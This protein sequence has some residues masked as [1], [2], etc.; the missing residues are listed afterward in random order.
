MSQ[1]DEPF[2]IPLG[3]VV[4]EQQKAHTLFFSGEICGLVA[5]SLSEAVAPPM[6]MSTKVKHRVSNGL[7]QIGAEETQRKRKKIVT[8]IKWN[9]QILFE[10]PRKAKRDPDKA[11]DECCSKLGCSGRYRC[12]ADDPTGA[13]AIRFLREQYLALT[14]DQQCEFIGQRVRLAT[15]SCRK[16]TYMEPLSV[17]QRYQL[18]GSIDIVYGAYFSNL[19]RCCRDWFNFVL[20]ISRDKVTQPGV[21]DARYN[22]SAATVRR[23]YARRARPALRWCLVVNWLLM[24]SVYYLHDPAH[25]FIYLPFAQRQAVYDL[26][27]ADHKTEFPSGVCHYSW[28][29]HIW[30][31]DSRVTHIRL[32]KHLRFALCP[33]CAGF[34]NTRFHALGEDVR[35][36]IKAKE[37]AHAVF[38]RREREA[39]YSRRRLAY[40]QPDNY[41]SM[42]AD[43]ADQSAYGLPHFWI[44]DKSVTELYRLRNHLMGVIVHGQGLYGF[45]FLDNFKHGANITI[46]A[47]H[48]VLVKEF[49]R[50]GRIPMPRTFFLQLDNTTKQCKSQYI[51]AYLGLLVGWDVFEEVILSFLP[52]GHTHEDIDQLFSRIATYLRRHDARAR[53]EFHEAFCHSCRSK[54]WG[55]GP[56]AVHS[57]SESIDYCANFSHLVVQEGFCV[58]DATNERK[59]KRDGLTKFHQIK[60]SKNAA[61]TVQMLVRKWCG[62]TEEESPWRSNMIADGKPLTDV[63]GAPVPHTVFK[64]GLTP[65]VS[66][67]ERMP[68]MQRK[69]YSKELRQTKDGDTINT[70]K[71]KM[72]RDIEKLITNRTSELTE[73]IKADLRT[74]LAL[75]MDEEDYVHEWDTSIYEA[76][77][78]RTCANPLDAQG[79]NE[80]MELNIPDSEEDVVLEREEPEFEADDDG[81]SPGHGDFEIDDVWLV[82][83]VPDDP[84]GDGWGL[85]R[86]KG[87]PILTAES[88]AHLCD[89]EGNPL[90]N[91]YWM[92][93]VMWLR[94]SERGE[95][96][97]DVSKDTYVEEMRKKASHR[98]GW[99]TVYCGALG[100]LIDVKVGSRANTLK[101]HEDSRDTVRAAAAA[102]EAKGHG[103]KKNVTRTSFGEPQKAKPRQAKKRT[104]PEDT[105]Q[106][107]TGRAK[108]SAPIMARE[109]VTAE[110]SPYPVLGTRSS[111]RR[112]PV[113]A[114]DIEGRRKLLYNN[115]MMR[116]TPQ[117]QSAR[118]ADMWEEAYTM[119]L[120]EM[121]SRLD[122]TGPGGADAE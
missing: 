30:K 4:T 82:P 11:I 31:N 8:L 18:E 24:L 64:D 91:Q 66:V 96:K 59:N 7:P 1:A 72:R 40:T 10:T 93:Q 54:T 45:S 122:S 48:R 34:I 73:E 33:D 86:I 57:F 25:E 61:G 53:Q 70:M 109:R 28:F 74:C 105:D 29:K 79:S 39:Y 116:A 108:G 16:E 67:L 103:K 43:G 106:E 15:G 88:D 36:D 32:R 114:Y 62:E 38:V 84:T 35:K 27:A 44:I 52:V 41:F 75:F 9:S 78:T 121:Q 87:P 92:V 120:E 99:D 20:G 98:F 42:I 56:E 100:E 2:E 85:V 60:I 17:L 83:D 14:N 46:E 13:L 19:D 107:L 97:T 71:T 22:P 47:V 118:S 110:P 102:A 101:I 94:R 111:K 49:E 23:G 80:A 55:N 65:P 89:V 117:E 104:P 77:S 63:H 113:P 51:I 50:R 68:P 90:T 76:H 5:T 6:T 26:F 58:K 12:R 112:G 81:Y 37:R 95:G 21:M 69:D 3:P 115:M 119:A